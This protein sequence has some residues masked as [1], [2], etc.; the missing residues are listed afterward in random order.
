MYVA[1]E[2]DQIVGYIAG[3][4]SIRFDCGG[5]LQY[6]YVARNQRRRGAASA[7]LRA[8]ANWF[9]EQGA[10]RICVDVGPEN[11][12][13]RSF[14]RQHGAVDLNRGWM[15]WEDIGLSAQAN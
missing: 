1:L 11:R 7:L 9:V 4:L 10:R 14:Y 13:A 5:E 8:L 15:V 3:H 12:P 6:L 2:Q